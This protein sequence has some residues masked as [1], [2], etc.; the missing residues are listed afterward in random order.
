MSRRKPCIALSKHSGHL[1]NRTYESDYWENYHSHEVGQEQ[2]SAPNAMYCMGRMI[3][4]DA[5]IVSSRWASVQCLP[6]MVDPIGRD[7]FHVQ[8]DLDIRTIEESQGERYVNICVLNM[9][10]IGTCR[11]DRPGSSVTTIDLDQ[12]AY[13]LQVT[14][15]CSYLRMISKWGIW[16]F[17]GNSYFTTQLGLAKTCVLLDVMLI[18]IL[19]FEVQETSVFKTS[20]QQKKLEAADFFGC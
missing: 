2:C 14:Q 12:C 3:L 15:T 8:E 10:S 18:Y 16:L 1:C 20:T 19:N 6:A 5:K 4:D 13:A 9:A 17:L 7:P 11:K